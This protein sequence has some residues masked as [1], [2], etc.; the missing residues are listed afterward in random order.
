MN[1]IM[2]LAFANLRRHK[3]ES[4]MLGILVM[5]CTGLLAGA[6]CAERNVRRMFPEMAERTGF[7]HNRISIA[8]EEDAVRGLD[9][10]IEFARSIV[11]S[12]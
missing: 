12:H 7:Y 11:A 1:K 3:T 5:L 6:F 9:T 10:I 2:R 8:E 4:V